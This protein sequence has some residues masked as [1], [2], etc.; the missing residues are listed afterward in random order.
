MEDAPKKYIDIQKVFIDKNKK[1]A[2]LL[3]GFV[4][5]YLRRVIHEDFI[6]EIMAKHGQ[7]LGIEFVDA[8]IRDFNVTITL[9]G[10]EN[11]P[12]SGRAIFASNHPLGGFD[13]L[14]LMHVLNNQYGDV[15][16]LA[17]DILANIKN[18]APLFIP[19][20][21]HGSMARNKAMLLETAFASQC[22]IGTFP[23]GLVS[24]KIKGQIVDLEWR[25]S[26]ITKAIQHQRDIVPVHVSGNNSNFFYRLAN[27]RKF[28][29]IKVNIEMFYLPDETF[30][31]RNKN[32]VVTF[33]KPISYKSLEKRHDLKEIAQEIKN[34]IYVLSQNPFAE[35]KTKVKEPNND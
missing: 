33:G 5:A 22:P 30:K 17:N 15:R 31:H 6:N 28:L 3:P 10:T 25:K 34:F 13:G 2:R 23:A 32:I 35:F 12:E 20:N 18:L 26:F 8:C 29:G 16:F 21:K 7:K 1:V 9:R 4:Y 11:L 19:I 27:L 24:R 14:V